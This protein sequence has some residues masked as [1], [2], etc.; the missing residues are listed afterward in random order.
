MTGT[1]RALFSVFLV[2]PNCDLKKKVYGAKPLKSRETHEAKN[3]EMHELKGMCT[4]PIGAS[5][6]QSAK[7][8]D[9]DPSEKKGPQSNLNDAQSLQSFPIP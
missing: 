3:R 6:L 1:K 4:R 5:W 9:N 2:K 7:I 8:R